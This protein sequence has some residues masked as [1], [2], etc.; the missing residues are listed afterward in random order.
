MRVSD[1]LGG[2]TLNVWMN[3]GPMYTFFLR[4]HNIRDAA[5]LV[6]NE[7][8]SKESFTLNLTPG[9]YIDAFM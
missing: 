8:E 4:Y 7:G 2:C 5:P 6:V 9:Y 1:T 3:V